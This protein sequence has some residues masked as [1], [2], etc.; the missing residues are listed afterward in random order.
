M[1]VLELIQSNKL[2]YKVSGKDFL[3]RCLNPEHDDRDPSLR[4]DKLTG[5][6]HCFSC[7]FKL[8]I[9]KYF[10]LIADTQ[11]IYVTKIRD[12]I[13]KIYADSYGLEMPKGAQ[14]YTREFRGISPATLQYFNAFTHKDYEDRVVFPLRD[15]KD[16]IVCFVGRHILSAGTPR[17]LN[18]PSGVEVPLFPTKIEDNSGTVILVE[19]IFDMLNLYDNGIRNV[20]ATMG[21]QGLGSVKGLNKEK[22]LG[23]KLQGIHKIIFLYDGDAPGQKAVEILKPHL[24]KSGFIVDNIELPED[25]DPGSLSKEDI[26]RLKT[27][28]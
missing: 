1:T 10:G 2:E 20:V 15:S 3:I 7:G 28:L 14:P 19:G 12:K 27:L 23:L 24:E 13:A 17:Y 6:G 22:I 11:S 5:I 21:T 8:N 16:K 25:T 26:R 9:Y 4:I 18:F